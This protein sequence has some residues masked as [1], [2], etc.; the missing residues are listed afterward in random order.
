MDR[1]I[2]YLAGGLFNAGER[3]HNLYLKAYLE[4]LELE[5]ILPQQEALKFF[6]DGVFNIPALSQDCRDSVANIDHIFVGNLDGADT[7]S[8]TATEF[9]IAITSTGRAVIY[10]TD[11]RT[12]LDREVG[13]NAMF[14]L[15][16]AEFVYYPCFFT[17]LDQVE[18][19]YRGLAQQIYKAVQVALQTV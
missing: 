8:G 12:A 13:R 11:F 14:G 15:P 2:V 16:G 1:V 19:Y 3:L 18:D 17:S 9:G 7:D 4:E 10:R 6:K 5:V